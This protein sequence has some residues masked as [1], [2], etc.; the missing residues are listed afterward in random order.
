MCGLTWKELLKLRWGAYLAFLLIFAGVPAACIF[1]V[2]KERPDFIWL[3]VVLLFFVLW[4]LT[5][6]V[7]DNKRNLRKCLCG[8]L[9]NSA[10]VTKCPACGMVFYKPA[11]E[12][13]S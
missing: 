11:A 4:F 8:Q 3:G 13:D 10:L 9:H 5:E 2:A 12:M 1:F 7:R 6:V